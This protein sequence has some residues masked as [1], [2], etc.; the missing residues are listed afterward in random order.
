MAQD[1]YTIIS[2][3]CHA[4]ADIAAY[5]DYLESSHHEE[6][7]EWAASYVNPFSDLSDPTRVRNWDT[8]YRQRELEADHQVAEVIFPN[9]VPPFFP[10]GQLVVRPP[11]SG[12]EHELRQ[13]GLHAHNRW[14][15]DW[16]AELPHRRAGLAQIFPND[17]DTAVAD[18]HWAK[19]NGLR[20]ILF[21]AIPPDAGV[22]ALWDPI[23]DPVWAAAAETGLPVNQHGGAGIPDIEG[24]TGRNFLML[25]EVPFF[26][27]RSLWHLIIGGVFERFPDLRFVMTEQAVGWVPDVLARMDTYWG[28]MTS[29]GRVGEMPADADLIPE[30][31]STYFQRNCWMGASMPSPD[32]ADAIKRLGVD[33]VMWGSDYPHR[34]GTYPYTLESLQ[35]SFHDWSEDDLRTL[36][37]GN[38]ADVYGFDLGPLEEIPVGPSV[39]EVARPLGEKP[40]DTHS[41]AFSPRR[42]A[43]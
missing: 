5:K 36:L 39:E 26:A 29:A 3:D 19:E 16:C 15:A 35:Y 24:A 25:M 18:I 1:R 38:A 41:M 21:S 4:G 43:H 8:E 9:T 31:P 37:A 17:V 13:A 32:E 7:E 14:L 27:N 20:G 12:R 23:Y 33:K 2:A 10:T 22:P 11:A 30:A 34:E 28:L 42:L 6:F 40:T